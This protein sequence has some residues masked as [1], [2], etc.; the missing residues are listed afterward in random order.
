VKTNNDILLLTDG[1]GNNFEVSKSD[2]AK[3]IV[4]E[5][6]VKPISNDDLGDVS[7]IQI[8]EHILKNAEAGTDPDDQIASQGC[9]R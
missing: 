9:C 2:Y 3:Q 1:E 4:K 6:A 7:P 8:V 5:L